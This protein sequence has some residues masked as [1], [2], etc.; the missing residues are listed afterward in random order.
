ML[1][2][3]PTYQTPK[4]GNTKSGYIQPAFLGCMSVRNFQF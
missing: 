3:R 2:R 4:A 1:R